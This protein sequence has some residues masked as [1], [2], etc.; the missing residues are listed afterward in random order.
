MTLE[1][2]WLVI[3]TVFLGLMLI[4]FAGFM[5]A[6]EGPPCQVWLASDGECVIPEEAVE[7]PLDAGTSVPS[8][9]LDGSVPRAD[10]STPS[11]STPDGGTTAHCGRHKN[12]KGK[13]HARHIRRFAVPKHKRQ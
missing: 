1:G 8:S 9:G 13:G 10:L 6:C 2:I 5:I 12:R 11:L 4:V 7:V 3:V